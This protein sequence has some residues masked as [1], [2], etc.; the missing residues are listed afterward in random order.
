MAA[1][2]TSIEGCLLIVSVTGDLSADE[3]ISVI[4]EYYPAGTVRDVIWDLTSGSLLAISK[5]GFHA[6]AKA[7]KESVAGGS[8][9]GGKTAY[10]GN[11]DVEYGLLRMYTA[12][13]E[14]T[15]VPIKYHVFKSLEEARSWMEE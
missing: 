12:I 4:R 6:I 1:I 5:N 3:T 7:A 11:A 14:V 13:A 2:D 8:R 15:G 10:V 9:Q